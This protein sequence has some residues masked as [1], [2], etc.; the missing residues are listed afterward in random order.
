MLHFVSISPLVERTLADSLSPSDLI[1]DPSHPEVVDN[2]L[3]F[4]KRLQKEDPVHFSTA[5]RGW[6]ITGYDDVRSVLTNDEGISADRLTPFYAAQ[7]PDM[8]SQ[9]EQLIRYLNTWVAFKDPP[10]HTRIRRLMNAVFSRGT[11]DQLQPSIERAV[12]KLL[13]GIKG[14]KEI[15]FV[16]EFAYPLPATVIMEML[17]LPQVDMDSIRN[18]SNKLQMFV[19]SSTTSSQKYR[20][21]EEGAIE[22]ANYFRRVV[23]ER[24]TR[25][26]GDMISR[27]LSLRDEDGS[28]TEDEVIGTCMLFLFGG[29][30]TTTNLIGNGVRALLNHPDQLHLLREQPILISSAVEEMLRYDGPT[31]ATVRVV[32]KAHPLRGKNLKAGDRVFAMINAANHDER[33]FQTPESLDIRRKPNPHLTF[34]YGRHFCLGAPLARLEAQIAIGAVLERFPDIRLAE[35]SYEYMDTLVMRG[36]R[37]M[38]LL[39]A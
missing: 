32:K 29:H 31:G 22:M 30:E 17:G 25:P 14:R 26:G 4:L 28:L 9:I 24:E 8:Q 1:F 27:L 33:I 20:L 6:V 36:V 34:N 35:A 2:P 13:M 19:G 23:H 39:L 16:R 15:D 37:Y 5:L 3:P 11:I 7:N 10:E 21:A 12:D 38:P 18:W